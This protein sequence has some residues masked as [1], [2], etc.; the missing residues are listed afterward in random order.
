MPASLFSCCRYRVAIWVCLAIAEQHKPGP[1]NSRSNRQCNLLIHPSLVF[2]LKCLSFYPLRLDGMCTHEF[3]LPLQLFQMPSPPLHVRSWHH[4]PD[5]LPA[6]GCGDWFPSQWA[7]FRGEVGPVCVFCVLP[8][9]ARSHLPFCRKWCFW[10][11]EER[12]LG[13]FSVNGCLSVVVKICVR[14]SRSFF[15]GSQY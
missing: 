1:C 4:A 2:V 13:S 7:C 14:A 8:V 10:R 6:C 11:A 12:V 5:R 3:S 15:G 9:W